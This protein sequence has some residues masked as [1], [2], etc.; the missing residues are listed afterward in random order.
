[1]KTNAIVRIIIWSLVL[2]LLVGVLVSF[3]SH[4]T[5]SLLRR[6]PTAEATHIPVP[7]ET[8]VEETPVQVLPNEET[9]TIPADTIREIEIEWVAGDILILTK[10]T[11]D[12]S[13][14]ESDVSDI[15]YSMIWNTKG[16]KL[17]ILFCEEALNIGFGITLGNNIS[18][19][20]YIEV[21]QDWV[22]NSLEIDAASATLEVHNLTIREMDFDGASGTCDFQNCHISD[23]DID[24]ASGD[25]Y[26]AG[27]LNTLDFDAASAS[28]IADFQNVPSRIDMDGMSGNL[29]IALPGDCGFTLSM[30]GMSSRFSSAFYGTTMKNN[31]HVYGD[32]RCRIDVD[33]MSCDVNIRKLETIVVDSTSPTEEPPEVCTDPDCTVPEEHYHRTI[34]EVIPTEAP[35]E[36][37][38]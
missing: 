26:Y 2:A 14:S 30:D 12:I 36:N 28:F 22:C 17:E 3:V 23:L 25:V 29:D 13:I 34:T 7:L 6:A 1:M 4:R 16:D 18:K 20:L 15:K 10:D 35:A 21:P 38:P 32:G 8:T 19:D 24:T 5:F 11:K 31:S 33:G 27:T 37:T 9:L